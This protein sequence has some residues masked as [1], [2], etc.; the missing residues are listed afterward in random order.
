MART[1]LSRRRLLGAA[2]AAGV[3][4]A[5]GVRP[6]AAAK[7][8]RAPSGRDLPN[9]VKLTLGPFDFHPPG[10]WTYNITPGGAFFPSAQAFVLPF[11]APLRIPAGATITAIT[12]FADA[13]SVHHELV[14]RRRR[15]L[16]PGEEVIASVFT[17]DTS[18]AE[19]VGIPINH[20]VVAGFSYE[21]SAQVQFSSLWIYGAEITYEIPPDPPFPEIPEP[22]PPPPD[23]VGLFVPF[24]G[25]TPRVYDSR[26]PGLTKL[27]ADEER[28]IPLAVP[29]PV[30]AAVFNL[31]VTETEGNGGFV[32]CF[33]ADVTWPGNSNINWSGPGAN[34]ANLVISR[35]DGTGTI[36]VR[37]GN[38]GTH[39][40]IDLVGTIQ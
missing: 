9:P 1:A 28:A 37:A 3:L 39:V 38:A 23:P 10:D 31:T 11:A 34:I 24:T 4:T 29:G 13:L 19:A 26:G 36:K 18:G 30:Q 21:L 7:G 14:V 32:A 22:P 25:S 12:V 8:A 6:A 27:A 5:S 35:V 33:P 16:P 15:L 20:T 17:N 2:G 40:V